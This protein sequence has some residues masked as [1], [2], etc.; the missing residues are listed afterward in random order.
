MIAAL[1]L[2]LALATSSPGTQEPIDVCLN[3]DGVQVSIPAGMEAGPANEVGSTCVEADLA[4]PHVSE[5]RPVIVPPSVEP[6][7]LPAP[8]EMLPVTGP[9]LSDQLIGFGMALRGVGGGLVA[10]RR[11]ARA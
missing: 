4:V 11:K 9:A 7:P 1:V 5:P 10:W 3:L 2:S 8:V 6:V